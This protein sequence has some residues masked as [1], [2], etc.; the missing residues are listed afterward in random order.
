MGIDHSL[1]RRALK[2]SISAARQEGASQAARLTDSSG[3]RCIAER[4]AARCQE[5]RLL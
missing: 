1:A 4:F 5:S 2:C 3:P